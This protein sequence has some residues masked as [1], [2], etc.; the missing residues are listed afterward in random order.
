MIHKA[1]ILA[2]SQELL[3]SNAPQLAATGQNQIC[4]GLESREKTGALLSSNGGYIPL[5]LLPLVTPFL[6]LH[7][8]LVILKQ[9]M[10]PGHSSAGSGL[11]CEMRVTLSGAQPT[12][13]AREMFPQ[14][15][16]SWGGAAGGRN[17]AGKGAKFQEPKDKWLAFPGLGCVWNQEFWVPSV[18]P[19][20][21]HPSETS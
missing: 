11:Q 2:L 16:A 17:R 5:P 18:S 20:Q 9:D 19:P 21:A 13:C 7:F 1:Q 12:G 4:L 10:V 14:I 8:P 15:S 6:A 3:L